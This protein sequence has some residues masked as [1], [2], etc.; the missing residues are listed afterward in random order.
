MTRLLPCTTLRNIGKLEEIRHLYLPWANHFLTNDAIHADSHVKSS[1]RVGYVVHTA[2]LTLTQTLILMLTMYM[3]PEFQG[4]GSRDLVLVSRP[5]KTTFLRS[6]SRPCWSW[7]WSWPPW[8]WSRSW[9]RPVWSWSRR[10]VL[11]KS[12]GYVQPQCYLCRKS[13][14]ASEC[15]PLFTYLLAFPHLAV[16]N[17]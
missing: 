10:V 16:S 13:K 9:S 5:I 17:S 1:T 6:W 3:C 12:W 8:S 2:E 14:L 15:A 11:S 4:C 7:S